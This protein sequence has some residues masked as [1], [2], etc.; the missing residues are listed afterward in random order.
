MLLCK[1]PGATSKAYAPST[2]RNIHPFSSFLSN[3]VGIAL[4][5]VELVAIS[6][7]LS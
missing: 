2:L 3:K 1:K 6:S 7:L 4:V 5:P